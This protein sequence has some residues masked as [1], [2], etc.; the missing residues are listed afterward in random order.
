MVF[1]QGAH[2]GR[3]ASESG[4]AAAAASNDAASQVGLQLAPAASAALAGIEPLEER[5]VAVVGPLGLRLVDDRR[6]HVD[7]RD[8]LVRVLAADEVHVAAQD[9]RLH[10]VG[11][12]HVVGHQQELL[13]LQPSLCFWI[14]RPARGSPG[15][16]GCLAGSGAARP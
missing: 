7:R 2:Q 8:R 12:D 11:V 5:L 9:A 3:W 15:P 6:R 10:V 13:A 4:A 16:P 14:T 1:K